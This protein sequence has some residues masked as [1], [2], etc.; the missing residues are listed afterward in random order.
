MLHDSDCQGLSNGTQQ[1]SVVQPLLT[2][3]LNN[4]LNIYTPHF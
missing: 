2:G 1:N 4:K 3:I